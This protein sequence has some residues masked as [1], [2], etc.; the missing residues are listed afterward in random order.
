MTENLGDTTNLIEI[1]FIVKPH[2][3]KGEL[4]LRLHSPESNLILNIDKIYVGNQIFK[5]DYS[6]HYFWIVL[7]LFSSD[8]NSGRALNKS[9]SKP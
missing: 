2:G 6:I 8:K 3:L 7:S 5:I 9:A 4:K 1:G